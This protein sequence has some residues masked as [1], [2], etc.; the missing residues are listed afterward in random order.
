MNFYELKA[1][2][3]LSENLHFAKTAENINISPSALSRIISR[4]E[5]EN[6]QNF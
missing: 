4:L 3:T 5:E 6:E 1:F 2:L